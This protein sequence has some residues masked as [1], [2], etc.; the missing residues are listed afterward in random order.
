MPLL[1]L[2]RPRL[3][4][5]TMTAVLAHAAVFAWLLTAGTADDAVVMGDTE[6]YV[7]LAS[8]VATDGMFSLD[9]RN[10]SARFEPGYVGV[11]ALLI[12]ARL[13][14]PHVVE[15]ANLW[16]VVAVQMLLYGLACY[17]VARSAARLYGDVAGLVCLA[18][19]QAGPMCIYQ[20]SI[21]NECLTMSLLGFLWSSMAFARER[22][23]TARRVACW[24]V[25]LGIVC[26]TR[27]VNVLFA[28]LL[29]LYLWRRAPMRPPMAI[30]LVTVALSFPAAWTARNYRAF[31]LPIVG[32]IDGFSSLYRGNILPFKE[33]PYPTDP[34]MPADAQQALA[35]FTQDGERYLWYKDAALSWIEA[36]PGQYLKQCVWRAAVMLVR[37]YRSAQVPWYERAQLLI[38][39]NVEL[40]LFVLVIVGAP[41][42]WRRQDL[43]IE[44]SIAFSLF[45]LAIYAA[46]WSDKRYFHPAMFLLAPVYACC[47]V[48]MF[49]R[50]FESQRTRRQDGLQ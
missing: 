21:R 36:H 46:I 31:K 37:L 39:G 34:D 45:T 9:G 10:P 50:V 47:L 33:L 12:R 6:E 7:E 5:L 16:P 30:L 27:S 20:Y 24:G 22:A 42:L 25:L 19:L 32:S 2:E 18:L 41:L 43:W 11:L 49:R 29:A 38:T 23:P 4:L 28:P 8:H 35:R 44:T 40:A 3:A 26:V 1:N 17:A 13:A 48:H 15:A 14:K